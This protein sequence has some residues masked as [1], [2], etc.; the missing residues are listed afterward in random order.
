ME[1]AHLSVG[2]AVGEIGHNMVNCGPR[3]TIPEKFKD[4]KFYEH[5]ANVTLVRTTLE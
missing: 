1:T 5:N 3:S 2:L 4:C